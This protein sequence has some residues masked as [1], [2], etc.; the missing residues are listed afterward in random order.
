M[1]NIIKDI[2]K[3]NEVYNK[4]TKDFNERRNNVINLNKYRVNNI[5]SNKDIYD[6]IIYY[7]DYMN[8]KSDDIEKELRSIIDRYRVKDITSIQDK[9][10]RYSL[11]PGGSYYVGKCLNDIFG[12]RI[13]IDDM[14]L[15]NLYN[16]LN[17]NLSSEFKITKGPNNQP[18][19]KAI[20]LYFGNNDNNSFKWELQ[21]WNKSDEMNNILSHDKYKQEY[22]EWTIRYDKEKGE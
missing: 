15:D 13:I 19:Y 7:H 10:K 21:I 6:L 12:L 9:I 11:K 17:N 1:E 18:T 14:D 3:I 16:Y 20:H 8:N 22:K 2:I 5:Y 4:Y